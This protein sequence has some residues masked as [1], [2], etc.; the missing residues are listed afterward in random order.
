[1]TKTERLNKI[2]AYYTGG[3]PSVFAKKLGVAPS[4]V[5]SWLARDTMD[6]DLIFAKCEMLSSTWLLTGEGDMLLD[7]EDSTKTE[8]ENIPNSMLVDKLLDKIE[9]QAI[10]VG[11]LQAENAELKRHAERLAALVNTDSTAHVG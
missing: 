9:Q 2:I 6:Y 10:E 5:S 1:M 8:L 7:K 11:R 4:T 3:K